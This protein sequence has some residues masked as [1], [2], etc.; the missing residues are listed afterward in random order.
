MPLSMLLLLERRK[1][2]KVP[3]LAKRWGPTALGLLAI[4]LI[5][6]PIDHFVDWAMDSTVRPF[7]A[8]LRS[9]N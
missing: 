3:R 1:V 9:E 8:G 2:A 4:P 6:H 5:I 7:I